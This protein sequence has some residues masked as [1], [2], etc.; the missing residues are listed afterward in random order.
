MEEHTEQ[1]KCEESDKNL[2]AESEATE[3]GARDTQV[4]RF[5]HEQ[6]YLVF[7]QV[8]RAFWQDCSEI[9]GACYHRMEKLRNAG[10]LAKER[11]YRKKCWIYLLTEK[12]YAELVRL[13]LTSGV[14]LFKMNGQYQINMD[15]DLKVTDLRIF[16]R[17]HGLDGW[18]SERV[19][20]DRDF[21]SRTPDGVLN[22]YGDKV[23][24]EFENSTKGRKRYKEIFDGYRQSKE[25]R[26][27]F[28]IV[29]EEIKDW[30]LNLDYD[31]SQIWFVNFKDLF[32]KK[33]EAVFENKAASFVFAR[34]L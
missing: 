19:L 25:Y 11:A 7:N 20:K 9:A 14:P 31:T 6:G 29:D 33:H 18:T 17:Q 34:I 13:G 26:R 27:V 12:G 30:A 5:I 16:F 1:V 15:H 32:R 8:R 4:F 21:K 10:Y 3:L 2:P 22:V 24:I 28:M 23:A